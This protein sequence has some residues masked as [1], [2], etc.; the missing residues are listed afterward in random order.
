MTADGPLTGLV[1]ERRSG[2]V[3]AEVA[4]WY[5][6]GLG[7]GVRAATPSASPFAVAETVRARPGGEPDV[8]LA[9]T[10]TTGTGTTGASTPTAELEVDPDRRRAGG[11]P[12]GTLPYATG[13]ALAGAA[14]AC[15]R[16]GTR[17]SVNPLDVALQLFLPEVM[18]ASYRSPTWPRP[19]DP[20]PAPGGGWLNCELGAPGAGD[21][22]RRLLA[23]LPA[24]ADAGEIAAAA[25]DWRLPVCEYLPRRPEADEPVVQLGAAS[26]P[27]STGP[28][29]AY[30]PDTTRA[31]HQ[32]GA[33]LAGV[34]VCD[35]TAMWAGPL[36]TWLLGRLGAEIRK[37]E[38]DARLD[39][40]RAVD[41]RGIHP[42]GRQLPP[43]DDSALYNALNSGKTR[44]PLDLSRH[45]DRDRLLEVI[46]DSDVVIDSF[47]P[48]VMPNL[49]LSPRHLR[50]FGDRLVTASL[51]AFPDGPLRPWVA[52]GNGVHAISGLG[53]AGNGTYRA[54][55]VTYPD[56]V[57]GLAVCAAV[58]AAL[59]GRDRGSAC[60]HVE[61]S[62]LAAIRPLLRF[63]AEAWAA[64]PASRGRT[65][66]RAA[67]SRAGV[68]WLDDGAGRHLY[69]VGPFRG[70]A[71]PLPL[72]PAPGL[73]AVTA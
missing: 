9:D 70:G 53:D 30:R 31:A 25:Q 14:L 51:P 5:L 11:L 28:A 20:L 44:L 64:A 15:V 67:E 8:V 63:P 17:V 21:D 33:P 55:S 57:A 41:G 32:S 1:V 66:L 24:G 36:A 68:A 7:A 42:R 3:E 52:Y 12:P 46:A 38:S 60:G 6:A 54:P 19:P 69:P 73:A 4:A 26:S 61:V 22:F 27:S 47:S 39:G 13:L 16:S 18:A 43:G 58:L 34:V 29:A 71:L 59:V 35:L 23:T 10:G 62:L 48:R 40:T 37:V 50:R 49:A 2:S 65:L 56:P 45:D 72:S